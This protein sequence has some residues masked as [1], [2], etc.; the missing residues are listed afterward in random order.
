M[1]I[2]AHV[3]ALNEQRITVIEQLRAKLEET[4]GRER[5]AEEDTVI[6]RMEADIDRIKSEIDGFVAVE[7]RAQEAAALREAQ[8]SVFGEPTKRDVRDA[9]AQLRSFIRGA[10]TGEWEPGTPRALEVNIRAARKEREIL[11]RGGSAE[12][13]RAIAWDTGSSAS[14]VPTTLARTLYQYMEASN[15]IMRAPTRK[16][17]T[18]SGEALVFPKLAAHA[19][20]TQ[21]IAQGTA[22][23]GEKT[24]TL[25]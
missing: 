14:L 16:I 1:D 22:L 8:Y 19:I 23:A 4:A 25:C 18:T 15:G 21:V 11:R 9:D 3:V 12:E 13:L 6:V 17:N 10:L 5:S 7:T 2:R 24:F 20:A